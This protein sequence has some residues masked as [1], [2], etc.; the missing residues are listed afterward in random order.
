MKGL[1]P[2]Q[3]R[4]R[5]V[6]GITLDPRSVAAIDAYCAREGCTRSR[7]V[8]FF[9]RESARFVESLELVTRTDGGENVGQ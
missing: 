1:R 7:A 8:E 5:P 2:H 3:T 9:L 6:I 4:N